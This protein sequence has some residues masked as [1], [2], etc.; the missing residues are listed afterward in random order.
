MQRRCG[1]PNEDNGDNRDST[2]DSPWLYREANEDSM[3]PP[4]GPGGRSIWDF[5]TD[6]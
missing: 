3:K 5:G 6:L 2:H 4:G 1:E